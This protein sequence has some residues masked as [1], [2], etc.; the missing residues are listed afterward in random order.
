MTEHTESPVGTSSLSLSRAEEWTLHDVLSDQFAADVR[1]NL[2]HR[3]AFETLDGGSRH[4]TRPQL[5]AMQAALARSHHTRRWEVDRPQLEG[6]LHRVS[7]ALE[8]EK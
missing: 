6:L 5:E 7:V 2:H 8:A 1:S 3:R 4:F